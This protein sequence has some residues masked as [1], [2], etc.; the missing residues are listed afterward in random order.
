[1]SDEGEPHT[2]GLTIYLVKPDFTD[3]D[4]LIPKRGKLQF[5]RLTSGRNHVGDLYVERRRPHPPKWAQFFSDYLEPSDFGQVSSSSALLLVEAE[6]NLFAITFGQGRYLLNPDAWV[7]RFGL[8]VTLNSLGESNVRSIDKRT[9]DAISRHSREQASR[10]ATAYEFELDMEQ[11]LL[12]AI[13]GTPSES[14]LGKRMSG[15]DALHAAIPTSVEALKELLA[16][17]HEKYLDTSYQQRF[18]WVDHISEVSSRGLIDSLD[19]TLVGRIVSGDFDGVWM[20]VP[21]VISWA[22]VDGFRWAGRGQPLL[23]DINLEG[24]IGSLTRPDDLTLKELKRKKVACINHD[25]HEIGEWSAYRCVHAQL[26]RDGETYLLSAGKWYRLTRDFVADVNAA[27]ESLTRYDQALPPY[28]DDSEGH[29]NQ[30]VAA[31]DPARYV[32]MD[33]KLVRHGG[34]GNGIEFCDMLVDC[35]DLIHIKRYGASS[36]LSHLFSQGLVSGELFQVDQQFRHKLNEV[37]P[38]THRLADPDLRPGTRE[39]QVVF[40]V[41]S[42]KP[43][44][45]TL[46]FFSRLNLKHA[47]RRLEGYGYRVALA[48]IEVAQDYALLKRYHG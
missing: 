15:M 32:L 9:F 10:E 21:D 26:D 25:G 2:Q 38:P 19:V 36:V 30:R 42:D 8:R 34:G 17:Y 20:A 24:F 40:A 14:E 11:D 28:E 35:Y 29:Y 47:A 6:G 23:R 1:M 12:R 13:T 7:E 46:P 16:A 22:D 45:L 39:Y 31:L 3:P 43:G 37:L 5:H 33:T 27:F 4:V 48:K 18:P 41:I 44:A